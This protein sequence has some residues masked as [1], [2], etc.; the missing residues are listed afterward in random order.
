MSLIEGWKSKALLVTV[1]G[2][3]LGGGWAV[4]RRGV[5]R[6]A[7]NVS[8]LPPTELSSLQ[9]RAEGRLTPY[10]GAQVTVGTELGGT[11]RVLRATEKSTVKKGDLIAEI[12][13]DEQRAA[14]TEAYAR[15]G[16][17][18]VDV[19]FTT[20]E[21]DRTRSLWATNALPVSAL[22]RADHDRDAAHARRDVV[23]ASAA[24]LAAQVAKSKIYAPIDG[25][26][27]ARHVEE[28]ETVPAGA[29]IATICDLK[30]TRI[31]AE[32]DELDAGKITLGA[33]VQVS[34]EGYTK[35]S[36]KGKV[37]EIPDAVVSR[38]MKPQDPGKPSD[39]RVLLVKIKLSEPAP[40]RLG[41]RVEVTITTA[42]H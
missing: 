21:L 12:A 9:I 14:L 29:S 35:E 28:G 34:V 8:R 13:A 24:R 11:L 4:Q 30:Q 18:N 39:T 23:T 20:S 10:P 19:S 25:V 42:R 41:Q 22:N 15:A 33:D 32:V 1:V 26:I 31:E 6:A 3:L 37:E 7:D 16:E 2:A 17:A 38:R 27:L 40:I 36:W 5:A